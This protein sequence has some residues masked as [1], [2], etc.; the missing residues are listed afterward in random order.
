MEKL[1]IPDGVL[2][3]FAEIEP[4]ESEALNVPIVYPEDESSGYEKD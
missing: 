2:S 3:A 4:K 1:A